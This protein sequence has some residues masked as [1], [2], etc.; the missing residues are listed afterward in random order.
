ME[1]EKHLLHQVWKYNKEEISSG[2][3]EIRKKSSE[4]VR[5]RASDICTSVEL[6]NADDATLIKTAK[7]LIVDMCDRITKLEKEAKDR[8]ASDVDNAKIVARQAVLDVPTLMYHILFHDTDGDLI[9]DIDENCKWSYRFDQIEHE[10]AKLEETPVLQKQ[11]Q[12]QYKKLVDMLRQDWPKK[13]TA[14]WE[15]DFDAIKTDFRS[16][17]DAGTEVAHPRLTY[18][19]I[20]NCIE[21]LRAEKVLPTSLLGVVEGACKSGRK[22]RETYKQ[23]LRDRRNPSQH[24]NYR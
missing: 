21:K 14:S 10:I 2:V 20:V 3:E 1:D 4:E 5:Q 6:D 8:Q 12:Q 23:T 18:D 16:I 13:K 11:K 9:T 19:E 7:E 15:Q 17:R 24:R 22:L